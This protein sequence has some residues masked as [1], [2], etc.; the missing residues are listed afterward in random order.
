MY[1]SKYNITY[2][3]RIKILFVP[4]T[5]LMRRYPQRPRNLNER[6]EE[7]SEARRETAR[8]YG[9]EYFHCGYCYKNYQHKP[10]H[11][12]GVIE[13]LR[14]HYCLSSQ[15]SVLDIGCAMGY[16][17]FEFTEVIP[18]IK[19]RG[20]D[21][22]PYAIDNAKPEV[23]PYLEV[24]N[25]K[26]LSKFKDKEFDLA[27]SITTIHNLPL[28]ECK[29]ALREIQRVGKKAFIQ[30]DAWRND[31]QKAALE[32][33]LVTAKTFMHVDSWKKL[34]EEAGYTGD[35]YWFNPLGI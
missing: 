22:S 19:V 29:Q 34:F 9:K 8:Q 2:I 16:T 26:D 3:P 17:L 7:M 20:I 31:D 27:L 14:D 25:A 32:K 33:W 6:F 11:W 5:N 23:K 4:E 35:Y 24:G 13:D 21:I 28:D 12:T 15:S 18:G 1:I 10:G 30:V